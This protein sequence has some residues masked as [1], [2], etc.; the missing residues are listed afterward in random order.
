MLKSKLSSRLSLRRPCELDAAT[1][2]KM[3][4]I[5]DD[6]KEEREELIEYSD[7]LRKRSNFNKKGSQFHLYLL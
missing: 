7:I 3:C 1:K 6:L 2:E 5:D 4:Y